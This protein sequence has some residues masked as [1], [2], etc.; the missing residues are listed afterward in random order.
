MRRLLMLFLLLATPAQGRSVVDM[1]G[2]VVD[3]PDQVERV[4]CLEVL[5]YPKMLMLG[6]ESRVAVM[7]DTAAPWMKSHQSQYRRHPQD[8]G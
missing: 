4:A 6:A 7:V 1:A 5:C 8:H 2:R 3:I